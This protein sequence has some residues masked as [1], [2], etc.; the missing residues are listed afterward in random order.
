MAI[1]LNPPIR[2]KLI[3][4][5]GFINKEWAQWFQSLKV[6]DDRISHHIVEVH[7]SNLTLGI[8][9]IGKII[10]F[11]NGSLNV[12]CY[13]PSVGALDVG[14][15]ITVM[16]LGTGNLRI[17]AVD[18][19]TIGNSTAGGAVISAEPGRVGAHLTL[20]LNTETQWIITAG[21]G[22]WYVV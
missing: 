16:K 4:K 3:D 2:T 6:F 13:L 1:Q 7:T 11:N 17:Q 14:S 15:L 22:V 19:D 21:L 9:D 20:F 10:K 12:N 5:N 18:S 8:R